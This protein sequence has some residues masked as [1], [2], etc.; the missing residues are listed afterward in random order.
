MTVRGKFCFYHIHQKPS[1]QPSAALAER[2]L[3]P[4]FLSTSCAVAKSPATGRA[5]G[6]T[7][8][9]SCWFMRL[10]CANDNRPHNISRRL[11]RLKHSPDSRPPQGGRRTVEIY[12]S[13]Y[14]SDGCVKLIVVSPALKLYQTDPNSSPWPRPPRNLSQRFRCR[15]YKHKLRPMP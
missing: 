6:V 8:L 12:E 3:E 15:L 14:Y 9:W 10:S 2:E 7:V 5:F 11:Q 4:R 13:W 1:F